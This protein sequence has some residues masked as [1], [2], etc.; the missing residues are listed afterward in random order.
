MATCVVVRWKARGSYVRTVAEGRGG[1]RVRYGIRVSGRQGRAE[2]GK[3]YDRG[4][5]LRIGGDVPYSRLQRKAWTQR[6]GSS[7]CCPTVSSAL[8]VRPLDFDDV[9][10]LS[11][12]NV[13]PKYTGI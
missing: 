1:G 10:E 8:T 12:S 4:H 9:P 11:A 6:P 7:N 13:F 2:A 3:H 5:Q